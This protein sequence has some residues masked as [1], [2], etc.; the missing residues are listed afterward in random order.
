MVED[1]V[2]FQNQCEGCLACLHLCPQNA[3]HLKN[4][5]SEKRWRNPD[6]TLEEI[7]SAN[8]RT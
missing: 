4:E 8:S 2:S 3:L 7:I 5:K 1:S 6:V